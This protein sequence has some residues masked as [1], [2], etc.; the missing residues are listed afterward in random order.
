MRRLFRHKI[1]ERTFLVLIEMHQINVAWWP[2]T[3]CWT[4]G[5]HVQ[6]D[7]RRDYEQ[8]RGGSAL[9]AVETLARQLHWIDEQGDPR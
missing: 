8:C 5:A 2:T 9:E 3:S 7:G 6:Q 4:A 1:T